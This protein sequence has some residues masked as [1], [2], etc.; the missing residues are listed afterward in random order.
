MLNSMKCPFE[1]KRK[2]G[3]LTFSWSMKFQPVE[4]V[5]EPVEIVP[6]TCSPRASSAWQSEAG[7]HRVLLRRP[8][9]LKDAA[10]LRIMEM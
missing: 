8:G 1:K 10:P 7:N 3:N 2:V 6:W 4:L 9:V 5:V